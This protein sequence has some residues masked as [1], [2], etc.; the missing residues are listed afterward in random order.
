M[1]LDSMYSV[2]LTGP[3]LPAGE[4]EVVEILSCNLQY[5]QRLANCGPVKPNA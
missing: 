5:E 1:P 3:G 2:L 4:M